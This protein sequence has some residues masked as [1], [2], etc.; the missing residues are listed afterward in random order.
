MQWLSP[1]RRFRSRTLLARS[2]RSTGRAGV[3]GSALLGYTLAAPLVICMLL[4]IGYPLVN[5]VL[6]SLRNESIIGSPSQM[7]GLANYYDVLGSGEFWAAMGRSCIWVLGNL[8]VQ[9][10]L[11]FSTALLLGGSSRVARRARTWILL[12]WAIPTVAL[13]V[14]AQ[15]LLNS[16]YG[17][18]SKIALGLGLVDQPL[19]VFGNPSTSLWTLILVNS[20][21]W[22][23]LGTVIIFG[24]MQTVPTELYE[25]ARVDGANAWRT[26][27]R[28]TFPLLDKVLFALG[29]VGGLWMFNILDSI[30]LI[31]KG[32]PSGASTTAP[33]FIY[34]T[35]FSAFEASDA[36]AASVVAITVLTVVA[37]GYIRL[38][39]P[40]D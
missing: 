40:K 26:F 21:H 10:V 14:I 15:W 33:V 28:I 34:D 22:F 4:I 20:W 27:W 11:G 30:Y 12:P 29:L 9:A 37:A 23:P 25:Q 36:A 3:H 8:G 35:A 1:P 6:L 31:T 16:N 7:V 13:A 24:A 2:D 5:A 38:A 39:R 18:I 17:V 19:N 32:G